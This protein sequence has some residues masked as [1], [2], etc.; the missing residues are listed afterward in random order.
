MEEEAFFDTREELTASPASSPGPA[1]PW[2]DGLD[3]VWQRRMRFMR[4]MGL[5]CSPS[6]QQPGLVDTV[7]EVEDVH[8]PEDQLE[9]GGHQEHEGADGQPLHDGREPLV[10]LDPGHRHNEKE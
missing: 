7:G 4:S 3:S 8:E 6:P 9:P 10:G 2:S 5:E 1:F